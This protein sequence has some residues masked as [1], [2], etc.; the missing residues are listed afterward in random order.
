M[1]SHL[2]CV[3]PDHLEAVTPWE[4][5]RRAAAARRIASRRNLADTLGVVE[6]RVSRRIERMRKVFGAD[7][8]T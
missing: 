8:S 5:R 2:V 1:F 7:A 3:N 4:N 6:L